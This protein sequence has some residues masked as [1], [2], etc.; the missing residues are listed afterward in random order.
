MSFSRRK[1]VDEQKR[2]ALIAQR[3]EI[4]A[5]K[6]QEWAS[7]K[8]DKNVCDAAVKK[9][10]ENDH[11]YAWNLQH[12][13]DVSKSSHEMYVTDYK[14]DSKTDDQK[15]KEWFDHHR[16]IIARDEANKKQE[17]ESLAM[18]MIA[19][20]EEDMIASIVQEEM[21]YDATVKK[22]MAIAEQEKMFSIIAKEKMFARAAIKKQEED[23]YSLAL[24][25]AE[26]ERQN[27]FTRRQ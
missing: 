15:T 21:K 20:E 1:T 19:Q 16:K 11:E 13:S 22:Q 2:E 24:A 18:A 27:F 7:K 26:E 17:N 6:K 23:D 8:T 9:Q 3:V 25:L 4:L 5:Q 10:I 14:K 12:G